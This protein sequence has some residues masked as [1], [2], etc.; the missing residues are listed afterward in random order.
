LL[1]LGKGGMVNSGILTVDT[2][3][4]D[5]TLSGAGTLTN[6]GTINHMG[7]GN[8]ILGNGATLNNA[9]SGI[10]DFHG[11]GSIRGSFVGTGI[12]V[13]AG[14]IEKTGGTADSF[15]GAVFNDKGGTL[16]AESGI[17]HID[18]GAPGGVVKGGVLEAG[19]GGSTT[20]VLDLT[21]FTTVNYA[22]SFTGSGSGTVE[23][24]GGTFSVAG[25]GVTFNLPSTLFQWSGGTVDVS[26]GGTFTNVATGVLNLDT[27]VNTLGLNGS[28]TG[29][30]LVNKGVLNQAGT[31]SLY[32]ENRANLFN[33][34]GATIDLTN[35]TSIRVNGG[36]TLVN[37]GTLEKTG[38]TNSSTIATTFTNNNGA[39]SVQTGMLLLTPLGGSLLNSGSFTAALG[40]AL[41][42]TNG[43]TVPVQGTFMGSGAGMVLL[44][45]GT[46]ALAKPAAFN[47]PAGLFQWVSGTIDVTLANLVNA[48]SMTISGNNNV[49]LNGAG[50]LVNN[51]SIVQTGTSTLYLQ[52]AATLNNTKNG[53]YD[54]QSDGA[55]SHPY[56]GGEPR[57]D[58]EDRRQ[59]N[60][61]PLLHLHQRRRYTRCR[62]RHSDRGQRWRGRQGR[63]SR[64]RR[65]RFNDGL[66]RSDRRH[67]RLLLRHLHRLGLRHRGSPERHAG[68]SEHRRDLQ[69][70]RNSL[71]VDQ[72]HH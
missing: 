67:Y 11:D 65:G 41:D 51:G 35:D 6:N 16:D 33:G 9:A 36:G 39:I 31:N 30:N 70:P 23:L 50:T 25:S 71:P 44:Q 21:D 12:L 56:Q 34:V 43:Q 2:T 14:T 13:N 38:G 64:G 5:L 46:L 40:S 18:P 24:S 58:R 19:V 26:S 42:L 3:G 63:R 17:L 22:G 59:Q 7:N 57:H 72:W 4:G 61:V 62:V 37:N 60:V 47:F 52:H 28:G 55:I 15:L 66:P 29:G 49:A 54:F 53:T 8:L 10:Y 68:R 1:K 69:F 20:A 45:G 32:L 27:T 48:G